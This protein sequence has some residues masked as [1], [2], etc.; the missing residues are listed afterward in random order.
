MPTKPWVN[1]G[2][3]ESS[4]QHEE[5]RGGGLEKEDDMWSESENEERDLT[6]RLYAAGALK[7]LTK[8]YS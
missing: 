7:T 8:G 2:G 6:G 1:F 3:K 4:A 5:D